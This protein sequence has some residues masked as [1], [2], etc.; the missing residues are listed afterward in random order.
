MTQFNHTPR[1]RARDVGVVLGTLPTG[2]HNAITDVGG[3][4]VG[5]STIWHGKGALQPGVGPART[6][7]TVIL[8]HPGNLFRE[9]VPAAF[10]VIN[11]FGKSVGG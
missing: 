7:V 6:G 2:E 10:H 11:G 9:K 8:P 4:Q 5:E 3:V 1:P